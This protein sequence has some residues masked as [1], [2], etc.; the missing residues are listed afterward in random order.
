MTFARPRVTP[1]VAFVWLFVSFVLSGTDTRAQGKKVYIS[2]DLEGI[3]GV[4]GDDQTG[5]GGAE[6]GRAR[7]LMAEDANA[8]IRGAFEGGATD[9]LVNDSHGGQRNLLPEDLD[10]RARLISHSFKRY[11]MMEGL[12]ETFDAI[13]FIGYHAKADAPRGL[14]A[15][16]GSGVV[17]DLQVNGRSVGEGGMNAALAAWYGVPVV[18]VSGDDVAVEEVKGVVPGIRG[19]VVKRAINIRAVELRPLADARRDIQAGVRDGVQRSKKPARERLSAYQ[20]RMQFRNFTIPEVASAFSEMSPGRAGHGAVQPA[21]HAR[22]VSPDPGALPLHQHRLTE[23]PPAA[24]PLPDTVG[25]L[26]ARAAHQPIGGLPQL[27]VGG[28]PRRSERCPVGSSVDR[29]DR[30]RVVDP[31]A[32]VLPVPSAR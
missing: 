7:K 20:V 12:D 19:V 9:V 10:P 27:R 31:E 5:P 16:T 3:S 8:A 1:F 32:A 29:A 2:V 28:S 18:A 15:H 26:E 22:S 30:A 11:G 13:V 24:V 6:Y 23:R 4:N 17:R 21:D 14:F 25:D